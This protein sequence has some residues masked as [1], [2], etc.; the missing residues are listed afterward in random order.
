M[1]EEYKLS[2]GKILKIVDNNI[3]KPTWVV[4]GVIDKPEAN[5]IVYH[6]HGMGRYDS[7]E[8]E[9][10]LPL[11]LKDACE[12]LNTICLKIANGRKLEEDRKIYGILMCS[13]ILKRTR[14][15]CK[16]DVDILRVIIPDDHENYPWDKN[17]K[18]IYNKQLI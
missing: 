3:N 13:F 9:L 18:D 15:I 12:L 7:L 16:T 10:N 6:T 17:C 14:G 8:L 1:N 2:N 5:G 11:S 4:H